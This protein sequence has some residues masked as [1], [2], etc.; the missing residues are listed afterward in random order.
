LTLGNPYGYDSLT[1][2]IPFVIGINVPTF[3]LLD[4]LS[5]EWEWFGSLY[6]N[7]ISNALGLN[8]EPGMPI[9]GK[10]GSARTD[11]HADDIKWS[12]YARKTID[13]HLSL[14]AQVANDHT[15]IKSN[16]EQ[17]NDREE[18]MGGRDNWW[19]V[20]KLTATL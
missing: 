12:L 11:Y 18:V 4:V 2:R 17:T 3:R 15:R 6:P 13:D 1:N 16:F 7:N 10:P 20:V 19:W 8:M 14:T 5:F 9:P